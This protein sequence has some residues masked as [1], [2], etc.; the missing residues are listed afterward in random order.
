MIKTVKQD[1]VNVQEQLETRKNFWK[2][3]SIGSYVA[4]AGIAISS[5]IYASSLFPLE[6]PVEVVQYESAKQRYDWLVGKRE[7]MNMMDNI[8][9][10]YSTDYKVDEHNSK[11]IDDCIECESA[12][13]RATVDVYNTYQNRLKTQEAKK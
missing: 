4:G 7:R 12:E 5:I 1:S 9:K 13:M 6:K 10:K 8:L 3:F 2:G 11:A